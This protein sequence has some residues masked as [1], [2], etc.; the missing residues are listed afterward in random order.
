MEEDEDE[1]RRDPKAAIRSSFPPCL[2]PTLVG[3]E[4]TP[5]RG[6]SRFKRPR[7]LTGFG[8]ACRTTFK[9]LKATLSAFARSPFDVRAKVPRISFSSAAPRDHSCFSLSPFA[10]DR[11]METESLPFGPGIHLTADRRACPCRLTF[12]NLSPSVLEVNGQRGAT[13]PVL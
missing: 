10:R 11:G 12:P 2:P 5:G 4:A 6:G 9:R 3:S 13:L 8:T 7:R 1:G